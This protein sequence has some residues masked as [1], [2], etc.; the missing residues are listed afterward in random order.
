MNSAPITS[1]LWSEALWHSLSEPPHPHLAVISETEYRAATER[2]RKPP[3]WV[4]PQKDTCRVLP[5]QAKV[6]PRAVPPPHQSSENPSWPRTMLKHS[7]SQLWLNPGAGGHWKVTH[8]QAP[9]EPWL[10]ISGCLQGLS[11]ALKGSQILITSTQGWDPPGTLLF[12]TRWTSCKWTQFSVLCFTNGIINY[13]WTKLDVLTYQT[14]STAVTAKQPQRW[15]LTVRRCNTCCD[16]PCRVKAVQ[17]RI[18]LP[19]HC[20]SS[21]GLRHVL[22]VLKVGKGRGFHQILGHL[23]EK[24]PWSKIRAKKQLIPATNCLLPVVRVDRFGE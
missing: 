14:A 21:S 11:I 10:Q 3:L 1:Y 2:V 22:K 4:T 7:R 20:V 16:L 12:F 17:G 18:E 8:V 15:R 5:P 23:A 13:C 9:P 24:S 19:S 6:L